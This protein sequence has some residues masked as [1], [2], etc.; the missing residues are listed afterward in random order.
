MRMIRWI[1]GI[2]IVGCA[3]L[4]WAQD[5]NVSATVDKTTVDV[6]S[7]IQLTIA[8]SGDLNGL[9]MEPL[10]L[11]S[12][13]AVASRS[14]ATNFSIR[15]GVQER[16][17]SLLFLLVPSQAGTFK[18][19]PFKFSQGKQEF[20]TQPIDITVKKSVLPPN[21]PSNAERFTL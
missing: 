16:S 2:I 11:P 7:P 8:I 6:A 15:G 3:A 13:F 17:M 12:G 20:Q 9:K 14:Q 19:G 10:A 5:V 1:A 21:L 18:L 4:A